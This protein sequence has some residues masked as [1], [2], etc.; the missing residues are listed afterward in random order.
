MN[1]LLTHNNNMYHKHTA[2]QVKRFF[3]L[4]KIDQLRCYFIKQKSTSSTKK[5]D[6]KCT[7]IFNKN[8]SLTS[9]FIPYKET[10]APQI[11][12]LYRQLTSN[13]QF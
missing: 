9:M 11:K 4:F 6:H 8:Y 5:V 3:T 12:K 2:T 13:Q 7:F 10:V 1:T